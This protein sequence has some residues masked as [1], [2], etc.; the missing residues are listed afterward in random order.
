MRDI[1]QDSL[2]MDEQN[3]LALQNDIGG[4]GESINHEYLTKSVAVN[5]YSGKLEQAASADREKY[6]LIEKLKR[7]PEKVVRNANRLDYGAEDKNTGD[8]R[9]SESGLAWTAINAGA[10]T[11]E[12]NNNRFNRS[13]AKAM[14]EEDAAQKLIDRMA[15]AGI[16]EVQ[17]GNDMINLQEFKIKLQAYGKSIQQETSDELLRRIE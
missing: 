8:F 2:G 13:A 17:D 7:E 11:R 6:K 1:F 14:A 16:A 5:P 10:I 3:T 15:A 9:W 4:V 12:I